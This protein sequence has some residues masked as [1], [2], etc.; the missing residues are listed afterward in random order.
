[1]QKLIISICKVS[2]A[3]AVFLTYAGYARAAEEPLEI[4]G[5]PWKLVKIGD[6]KYTAPEGQPTA[7]IKLIPDGEKVEGNTGCNAFGGTYTLSGDKITLNITLST[8]NACPQAAGMDVM[9]LS[10]LKDTET[11][12]RKGEKLWLKK[13]GQPV[14][15]FMEMKMEKK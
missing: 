9:F 4:K 13:G 7:Y 15:E 5:T 1:M 8:E 2:L 12:K 11:F 3:L 14:A 6:K 10:A